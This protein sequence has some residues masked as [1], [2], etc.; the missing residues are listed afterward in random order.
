[1]SDRRV[2]WRI[3]AAN[4]RFVRW[5]VY[6]WLGLF[7]G[8]GLLAFGL[9]A[10][11]ALASALEGE[12]GQLALLVLLVLVGG[13]FSV[14]YL[15]PAIRSETR[16]PRSLFVP[17]SAA[18]P[19]EPLADRYAEAFSWHGAFV[20]AILSALALIAL[21]WLDGRILLAYVALWFVLLPI[22]SGFVVW[23][24]VDPRE[25]SLE[26]RT[27]TVP[28]EAIEGVRRRRLG[29]IVVYRLSYR[30]G[31]RRL[32]TPSWLTLTPEAAAAV[33]RAL[34]VAEADE[35]EPRASNRAVRLVAVGIGLSFLGLAV[36]IWLLAAANPPVAIYGSL[37]TGLLGLFFCWAGLAL[38]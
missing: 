13:P 21:A 25:P 24:R 6:G 4:S 3:D 33:D 10:S 17:D 14:L 30:S 28:L 32:S 19:E 34:E 37:V 15:W 8:G 29:G 35:A 9:V 23:G 38:A 16:P 7:G 20:A 18:D 31:T 22:A 2:E 27:G 5:V 1:M 12:F 26:Y 36:A 11:G